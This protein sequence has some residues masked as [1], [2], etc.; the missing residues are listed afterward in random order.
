[1][2]APPA[3]AELHA[4]SN[5]S[6][7]RGASHPAELIAR[8]AEHGYA[9]LALTDECSLAGIVRAHVAA[10]ET[11]LHLIVGSE[12]RLE[13]GTRLVLLAENR[14]GYGALAALIT[15]ARRRVEKGSYRLR[16]EDFDSPPAHCLAL[17]L[18]DASRPERW[19]A[20]AE[21]LRERFSARAWIAVELLLSGRDAE[22]LE[23]LR[24]IGRALSLPLAA[25]GDVHMH[26]RDR[27]M[28]QDA[29]T[30][31]RLKRP[32][33]E[34]RGELHPNG[35]RHLRS[36]ARLARL[37]PP[38]LLAET[39]R[40]AGRCRFGLEELRYEYPREIVP[41]GI[42]PA[43]HLRA[44]VED[45]AARRWPAGIP[46]AARTQ[47]EH[48]LALIAE[49]AYEPYFLTVHDIV[50]F[51]RDR[52]I[53]CQGRGSAAN[54]A[55]CYCLGITELDP[56]RSNLLFER[57]VSK[58]RAEPPDIDVDF[59]HERREEVIQY[60]YGKYGRERAALAATLI[61]YRTRSAVRDLGKAD[62]A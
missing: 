58:E 50:R 18:P 27:R 59:E 1:M 22:Q 44:L 49:L 25:A 29:L 31:I 10:K 57:F 35:E 16:R 41:Q 2:S 54:S 11:G 17:W 47:L 53:L 39:I 36:R 60:I 48:E 23:G 7:L 56:A 8:A 61:T 6:F 42:A 30:A 38:E 21:W 24:D 32:L 55:V 26:R 5:F 14:E 62:R 46:A 33:R 19:R 40:I 43:A 37:Y 34:I 52:G 9:A 15:R 45:G 20:E 3:Y 28:L 13:D 4:L 12:L 51:A